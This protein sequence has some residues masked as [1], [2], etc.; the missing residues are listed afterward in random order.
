M[1]TVSLMYDVSV[2]K[3]KI[4]S[5]GAPVSSRCRLQNLNR[6]SDAKTNTAIRNNTAKYVFVIK[7]PIFDESV[8]KMAFPAKNLSQNDN[9][10]LFSD[11]NL[12]LIHPKMSLIN[13]PIEIRYFKF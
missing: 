10:L 3:M 12:S 7:F 6:S 1:N 9:N 13:L 4:V 11:K 2:W 8:K 5:D